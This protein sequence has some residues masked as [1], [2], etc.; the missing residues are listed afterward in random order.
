MN[1]LDNI[2][3]DELLDTMDKYVQTDKL[4]EKMVE[5][6]K[7]WRKRKNDLTRTIIAFCKQNQ[8]DSIEYTHTEKD[9]DGVETDEKFVY[10]IVEC[11]AFEEALNKETILEKMIEFFKQ[12]KD[13]NTLTPNEKAYKVYDYI[14][15]NRDKIKVKRLKKRWVPKNK[16]GSK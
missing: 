6:E 9:N 12:V 16:M 15:V 7:E 10:D 14:Y 13:F 4:L 2:T 5:P 11:N 8:M 3:T 1:E